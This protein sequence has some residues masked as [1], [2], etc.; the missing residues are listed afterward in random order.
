MSEAKNLRAKPPVIDKMVYADVGDKANYAA[1][2]PN[3]DGGLKFIGWIG[4]ANA[5]E[6]DTIVKTTKKEIGL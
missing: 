6:G 5:K 3:K 2:W 1:C 4:K